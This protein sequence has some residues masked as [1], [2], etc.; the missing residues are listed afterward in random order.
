M[1]HTHISSKPTRSNL[2][3][4][5]SS[6]CSCDYVLVCDFFSEQFVEKGKHMM[7]KQK[8][9]IVKEQKEKMKDSVVKK[10]LACV[11]GLTTCQVL[12]SE[13][14]DS[15]GKGKAKE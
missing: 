7:K 4:V 8:E 6:L 3:M 12:M 11:C 9:R 15:K 2:S 1:S 13:M 14:G 5:D 10:V